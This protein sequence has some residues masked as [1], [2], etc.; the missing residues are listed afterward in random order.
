MGNGAKLAAGLILVIAGLT[1]NLLSFDLFLFFG[2]PLIAGVLVAAYNSRRSVG[3]TTA[4][5]IADVLR[6]YMGGHLLWSSV[7][8][9]STDMQPVIHHPIGPL[10]HRWW[11][12]G[13]SRDQDHRGHRRA[14][15]A[16]KPVR[17]WRSCWKCRRR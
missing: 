9:W 14:A 5:Q 7:R 3:R 16:V 6:I 2:L 13:L 17:R 1:F 12:W 8:Y 10:S 4:E 11:R 15:V